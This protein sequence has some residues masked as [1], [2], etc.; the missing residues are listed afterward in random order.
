MGSV[1]CES[2]WI[3]ACSEQMNNDR[4]KQNFYSYITVHVLVQMAQWN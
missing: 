1:I 2:L 4:I 3:K